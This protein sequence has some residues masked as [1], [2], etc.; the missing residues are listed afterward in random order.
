VSHRTPK[1]IEIE[2]RLVTGKRSRDEISWKMLTGLILHELGHSFLYHHW[3]L[4]R[5]GRFRRAFGE[6]GKAYRVADTKWVDFE[7]Q[8]A[9]TTLPDF[10]T[11]YAATHPQEDFAETFRIYVARRGRLRG[12]FAEFGRKRK[13][14]VLF[15]KF[16]VLDDLVR[17]LRGR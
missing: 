12:L 14:V 10:V 5:T 16:L 6:L 1:L 13:G 8:G 3:S 15:E 4:T 11:T 2:R 7:R 17:R 9:T